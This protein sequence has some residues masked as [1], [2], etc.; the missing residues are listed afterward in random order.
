MNYFSWAPVKQWCWLLIFALFSICSAHA[1]QAA[2]APVIS[3]FEQRDLELSGSLN[4]SHDGVVAKLGTPQTMF[5][6][7]RLTHLFTNPT[8][9]VAVLEKRQEAIRELAANEQLLG[10][11]THLLGRIKE[12]EHGIDFFLNKDLDP[13]TQ[14][15]LDT[16]YYSASLLRSYNDSAL[17]LTLRDI[18]KKFGLFMPVIEHLL[19]HFAMDY[20]QQA[21]A[22]EKKHE[23]CHG[24]KHKHKHKHGHGHG[25]G[26]SCMM[27][28]LEPAKGS[29]IAVQGFFLMLKVGHFGMHAISIYEMVE[30]VKAQVAVL[31]YVHSNISAVQQCLEAIGKLSQCI[32]N[33]EALVHRAPDL[34]GLLGQATGE[35]IGL[36]KSGAFELDDDLGFFST[37]GPTLRAHAL[38]KEQ[39]P[40]FKN[41][42]ETVGELD[43]YAT[44]ARL[45]NQ[46]QESD[47]RM[48]FVRFKHDEKKPSL[49]MNGLWNIMLNAQTVTTNNVVLGADDVPALMIVTGPNKAGKSSVLKALGINIILAQS[50]GIACA[51]DCEMTLFDA[52]IT[53]ITVT[54]DISCDASLMVAE[55][56]RADSC[57]KK[58]QA[59]EPN[60]F[61]CALI[62]DSLFKGTTFQKREKLAYQF[63]ENLGSSGRVCGMVATHTMQLTQLAQHDS[64]T[65]FN[66][67]IPTFETVDGKAAST[68]TLIPGVA[69][70]DNVLALVQT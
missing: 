26:H 47:A 32:K 35:L 39:I 23:H 41:V 67:Y 31:D 9:N 38:L 65:F 66:A 58:I 16:Y 33:N 52:L 5:G 62:D 46:H 13:A 28:H 63:V 15:I 14:H 44:L 25:D 34:S 69:D 36:L 48:C 29:S 37:V 12:H 4:Q 40:S 64:Q 8:A 21:I 43:A 6:Y 61:A 53:Y 3:F 10:D 17:A 22:G 20:I 59:L 24:H 2:E 42:L 55:L 57:L 11:V 70:P 30:H 68:F 7:K 51:Q 19:F 45:V 54:D 56:A 1:E 18:F 50:F 49:V 27:D 60:K